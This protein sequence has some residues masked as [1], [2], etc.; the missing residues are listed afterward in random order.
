MSFVTKIEVEFDTEY[1]S[2][3]LRRYH[4][5]VDRITQESY[6]FALSAEPPVPGE[7]DRGPSES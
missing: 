2:V 1:E 3:A 7:V 5:L 6:V 4:E